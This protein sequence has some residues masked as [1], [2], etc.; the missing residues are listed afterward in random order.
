[1]GT[2]MSMTGFAR[3]SGHLPDG[4]AYVWELR[5]VNGRGLD[6]RL[7][8]PN[9][10]DALEPALREATAKRMKRGNVSATLTLK[11]EE[12]PRLAPDPQALEQALVL[13]LELVAR[14]PGAAPP[15]AEALLGLPGVLR[16]ESTEPDEAQQEAARAALT[17]A[18]DKALSGLVQARQ[19][20]GARLLAILT[21]LLK[22]IAALREA[23][24]AEAAGQPEAQRARLLDQLAALLG[25]GGRARI[26]EER[27][28]QE[29]ALLAQKSDVREELDRL[30]AHIEAARALLAAGEGA[31]RKLDFL[32]Q[33]FVREANTLCSKSAS[34]PL[35]RIGLDL[36]A[37]IERLKEQAANV[38]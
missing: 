7:R 3:E 29:V 33:E 24:A 27:L 31:G 11:R 30:A 15:R 18:Y 16:P 28:A 25:E 38:E 2:L 19:G 22:E 10:Q 21:G 13:A 34:V 9:G 5:S 12:R 1:M 35:T 37:A 6:F 32:T 17:K 8:L 14:I 26:P 20:E 36:K 23:A 4:T